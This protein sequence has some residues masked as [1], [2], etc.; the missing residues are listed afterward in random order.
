M[1]AACPLAAGIPPVMPTRRKPTDALTMTKHGEAGLT[2]QTEGDA[3]VGCLPDE[4]RQG[5]N[6]MMGQRVLNE[7]GAWKTQR[8]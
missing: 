2:M 4:E 1:L 5:K 8:N 3:V 7:A 6:E